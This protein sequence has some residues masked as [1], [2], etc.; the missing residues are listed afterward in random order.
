MQI[1]N[2][3]YNGLPDKVVITTR[4]KKAI[5]EFPINPQKTDNLET[6]EYYCETVYLVETGNTPNLKERVLT[7]YDT[8]LNIASQP[9]PQTATVEDVI[10]AINVLTELIIGG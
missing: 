2:V 6:D 4:G 3:Y 8:W 1:K 9:T 10:E 7:D 5:I